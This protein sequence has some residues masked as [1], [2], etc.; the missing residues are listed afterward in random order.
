MGYVVKRSWRS[1]RVP[2]HSKYQFKIIPRDSKNYS[3]AG[4]LSRVP[5]DPGESVPV[6]TDNLHF[7]DL[8]CGGVIG[9]R[10]NMNS[11]HYS[12]EWMM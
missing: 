2:V 9:V 11:G 10:R 8:P 3:N 4:A 7:S 1:K 6:M 12:R 5:C